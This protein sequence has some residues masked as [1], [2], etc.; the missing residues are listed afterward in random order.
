MRGR[1]DAKS[2]PRDYGIARKFG[3]GLRDR[4]T[5]LGTLFLYWTQN[6]LVTIYKN[7]RNRNECQHCT[8]HEQGPVDLASCPHINITSVQGN[9]L[10]EINLFGFI[11]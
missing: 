2:N 3:S 10:I 7:G 8:I 4:K 11:S 9:V 6:L 5:L 1:W